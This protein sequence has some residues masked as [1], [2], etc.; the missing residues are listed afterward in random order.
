MADNNHEYQGT[1]CIILWPPVA[2]YLG[3]LGLLDGAPC[4]MYGRGRTGEKSLA[5]KKPPL[6][7]PSSPRPPPSGVLASTYYSALQRH[8]N[9]WMEG[10][11]LDPDSG[12]PHLG[13]ALACLAILV[14]AQ[15][16]GQL[17]DDRNYRGEGY[18]KCLITLTEMVPLIRARYADKRPTHYDARSGAP[19]AHE[20]AVETLRR[21][22]P[23]GSVFEYERS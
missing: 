16:T 6:P 19:S 8:I 9:A 12:V 18:R 23:G 20:T 11:N 22:V 13:H 10:E 21:R 5:D 17:T 2:T 4:L 1:L 3:A 14:D 15:M 7:W